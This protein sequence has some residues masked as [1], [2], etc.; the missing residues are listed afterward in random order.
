MV[1]FSKLKGEWKIDGS[2]LYYYEP[3]KTDKS[4]L[5][6]W[7]IFHLIEPLPKEMDGILQFVL[8]CVTDQTEMHNIKNRIES[9]K[10]ADYLEQISS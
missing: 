8:E 1:D 3:Q 9:L 4:P 6:R 10:A 2:W 5:T 7:A